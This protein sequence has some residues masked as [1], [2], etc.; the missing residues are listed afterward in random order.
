MQVDTSLDL[1][2][3]ARRGKPRGCRDHSKSGRQGLKYNAGGSRLYVRRRALV[4]TGA[5]RCLALAFCFG[6][7]CSI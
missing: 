3:G 1:S 4:A 2:D 7:V 6:E 5:P